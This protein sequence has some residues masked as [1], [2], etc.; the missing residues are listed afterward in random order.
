[1]KHYILLMICICGFSLSACGSDSD[2]IKTDTAVQKQLEEFKD[3]YK[4]DLE[5]FKN[6]MKEEKEDESSIVLYSLIAGC[7]SILF[8][9]IS[10][11]ISYKLFFRMEKLNGR[12]GSRIKREEFNKTIGE[13]KKQFPKGPVSGKS[14]NNYSE[15]ILMK[16]DIAKLSSEI[17]QIKQS[18]GIVGNTNVNSGSNNNGVKPMTDSKKHESA[19]R[20]AY[21]GAPSPTNSG[22]FLFINQLTSFDDKAYFKLYYKDAAN[23]AEFELVEL[24]KVRSCDW[25]TNVAVVSGCNISEAKSHETIKRGT[26]ENVDNCWKVKDKMEIKLNK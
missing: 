21:L 17:L 16:N 18:K 15:I 22:Q 4:A 7:V 5:R 11:V 19:I 14:T 2:S 24:Q 23:T 13:L 12:L 1:M 20:T 26:L 6:E 3:E 25:L 9:I 8:S 10:I